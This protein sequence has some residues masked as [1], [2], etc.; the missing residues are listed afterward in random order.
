MKT[1]R[2]RIQQSML[3]YRVVTQSGQ[4]RYTLTLNYAVR[5]SVVCKEDTDLSTDNVEGRGLLLGVELSMFSCQVPSDDGNITRN[6]ETKGHF[7]TQN[8]WRERIGWTNSLTFPS[9]CCFTSCGFRANLSEALFLSQHKKGLGDA[10]STDLA[11]RVNLNLSRQSIPATPT[12]QC[13]RSSQ[14][15]HNLFF[16]RYS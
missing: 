13:F 11:L 6:S 8:N 15:R 4:R 12:N 1:A 10:L 9:L 14:I 16:W 7:S 2:G 3:Y 5:Q